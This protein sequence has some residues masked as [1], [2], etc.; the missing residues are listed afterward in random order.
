MFWPSPYRSH[1]VSREAVFAYAL[2]RIFWSW[3]SRPGWRR[4]LHLGFVWI[5]AGCAAT[6]MFIIDITASYMFILTR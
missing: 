6:A 4:R 1:V 5:A 2:A 3:T